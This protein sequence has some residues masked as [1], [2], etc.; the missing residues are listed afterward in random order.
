M[1]L[2]GGIFG[3]SGLSVVGG[4][5]DVPAVNDL[6]A[7][8][9]F[10]VP[11]V[12]DVPVDAFD[13][14][15][16]DVATD[17]GADVEAA[18]RCVSDGD[19]VGNAAGPACDVATGRCVPCTA[20]DDVCP[21]GRYCDDASHSCV[22]GCRDDPWPSAQG[23]PQFAGEKGFDGSPPPWRRQRSVRQQQTVAGNRKL[24][25]RGIEPGLVLGEPLVPHQA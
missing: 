19:C 11:A 24:R 10:D 2:F 22:P 14:P 15:S 5:D 1:V 8:A 7:D 3:C 6:G 20:T 25:R 18:F 21:D 13:A 9:G 16:M 23:W 12:L 4:G 17:R